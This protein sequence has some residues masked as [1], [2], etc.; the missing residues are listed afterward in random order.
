[1]AN[2]L[3]VNGN[4]NI[5]E[6]FQYKIN[7]APLAYTNLASPLLAGTNIEIADN[8][9]K[10]TYTYT[11]HTGSDTELGGVK[12][13][14]ETITIQN[15][16]I[17]GAYTYTLP[18]T[19]DI[20]LGGVKVDG[21]TI[22]IDATSGI[23]SSPYTYTLPKATTSSLGGVR[24]GNNI[25]V[26][27]GVISLPKATYDII[28]GVKIGNNINVNDCVISVNLPLWERALFQNSPIDNIYYT[29]GNVMIGTTS[30][31]VVNG[32]PNTDGDT[33][34]HIQGNIN[35]TGTYKINGN[36]LK[37]NDLTDKIPIRDFN[38]GPL[39]NQ[40]PANYAFSVDGITI[41]KSVNILDAHHNML[42]AVQP[43][44]NQNLIDGPGYIHNK[45]TLFNGNYNSL[46]NKLTSGTNIEITPGNVINNTYEL[47]KA[48]ASI[49]A[50]GSTGTLGGVMV[51]NITI[52]INPINGVITAVSHPQANWLE[53]NVEEK[54]F[55]QNK[56][57]IVNSKWTSA[58]TY[59]LPM[60]STTT[61]G[62]VKVGAGLAIN[63]STGVLTADAGTIATTTTT[64][65]VKIGSGLSIIADGTLSL[66]IATAATL[67]GVRVDGNTIVVYPQNDVISSVQTQADWTNTDSASRAF[68]QNKPTITNSRWSLSGTQIWYNGG[69]VGIGTATN[70]NGVL[71]DVN[72]TIESR[73]AIGANSSFYFRGVANSDLSRVIIAGTLS[74]DI[75]VNDTVLRSSNKLVLQSG[76]GAPAMVISTANNVG[77]GTTNPFSILH[78]HKIGT[79]TQ[80]VR[81]IL[82]DNIT[83]ASGSRG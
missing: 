75:A 43:D 2:K 51:D 1:L 59:T 58:N 15:G 41:R 48:T 16:V 14:N 13:D 83:T 81:I 80:D 23:I 3:E 71:L 61:L 66:P 32:Q 68:I 46:S 64:G 65:V 67:G 24:I 5:H 63:A 10:S 22:K 39:P 9:I 49:L 53:T 45:P 37:Y 33:K 34:L 56:P 7:N 4:I 69:N 31:F 52:Q 79:G 70:T 60:A 54:S 57:T 30:A 50:N 38:S 78:L 26:N 19:S 8:T 73:S 12:V 28:G 6:G 11:L 72:G 21:S 40:Y 29:A 36:D 55:I 47:P 20:V 74:T 27:D 18:T 17:S 35:I 82:S 44:W 25:D 76:T 42:Y 62:G 77:I